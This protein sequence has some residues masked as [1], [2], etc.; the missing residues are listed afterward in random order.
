MPPVIKL[1]GTKTA[2]RQKYL[3]G[4]KPIAKSLSAKGY[5]LR[6]IAKFLNEK[7]LVR[8]LRVGPKSLAILLSDSRTATKKP[9]PGKSV[10]REV[11][12]G[13]SAQ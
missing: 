13:E 2:D 4:L 9:G 5:S 3:A 12:A 1:T 7:S 11:C 8:A 6:Q 10:G